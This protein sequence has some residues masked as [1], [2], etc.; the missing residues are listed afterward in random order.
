MTQ[1]PRPNRRVRRDW[2]TTRRRWEAEQR[3]EQQQAAQRRA[4]AEAAE[5]TARRR[6]A[7]EHARAVA[8]RSWPATPVASRYERRLR[9][10][11]LSDCERSSDML[12]PDRWLA[13]RASENPGVDGRRGCPDGDQHRH[14]GPC[15]RRHL[16]PLRGGYRQRH[17]TWAVVGMVVLSPVVFLLAWIPTSIVLFVLVLIGGIGLGV[18][19]GAARRATASD[20][21]GPP[22]LPHVGATGAEQMKRVGASTLRSSWMC[23]PSAAELQHQRDERCEENDD[24]HHRDQPR[25]ARRTA[26]L[27][28]IWAVLRSNGLTYRE[29][30]ERHGYSHERVRQVIGSAVPTPDPLPVRN[31]RRVA[32]HFAERGLTSRDDLKADLSLSDAQLAT[33]IATG[34]VPTHLILSP[35]RRREPDYELADILDALRVAWAAVQTPHPRRNGHGVEDLR[36]RPARRRPVR[37]ALGRALRLAEHL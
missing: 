10:R 27:F 20:V 36:R 19:D 14:D 13:A 24:Y 29:I 4:R 28:D 32:A 15:D 11:Y 12:P 7:A 9:A 2:E 21:G 23:H 30:G 1:A 18:A 5:A 26:P 35:R 17:R 22:R 3:R 31:A 37:G 33:A 6:E 34:L 8:A 25:P 16:R